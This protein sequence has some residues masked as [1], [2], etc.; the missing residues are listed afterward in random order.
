MADFRIAPFSIYSSSVE[1]GYMA[2]ISAS[3]RPHIDLTNMKTDRYGNFNDAPMQGPFTYKYVGG[4]Q[5]RHVALNEGADTPLTRPELFHISMSA[6]TIKVMG[7][8]AISINRPRAYYFRDEMAKRPL[9]VRNIRQTTGST[10]IGN[11]THDY[12]ILQTSGRSINNRAFVESQGVGFTSS[13]TTMYVSGAKDPNRTLPNFDLTGTNEY[14]FV[15]RF[16]APGGTD[17]SSR[18]VLDTYAEEYAPNNAMPWRNDSVRS[19]LRSDLTRHTPKATDM[20]VLRQYVE[21]FEQNTVSGT[22]GAANLMWYGNYSSSLNWY[23]GAQPYTLTPAGTINDPFGFLRREGTT[24]SSN[25]GPDSAAVGTFYAYAESSTGGPA[26]PQGDGNP[27][28]FYAMSASVSRPSEMSFLYF[29]FGSSLPGVAPG[30]L[31]VSASL[32]GTNWTNL[33]IIANGVETY[34]IVGEQQTAGAD[35]WRKAEVKLGQFANK[36]NVVFKIVARTSTGFE[37]DIAIDQIVLK[38]QCGPTPTLYHTDNRNTRYYKTANGYLGFGAATKVTASP[39]G[40][41]GGIALDRVNERIYYTDDFSGIIYRVGI[42]GS[43]QVEVVNI[44]GDLYDVAVD[45]C[46]GHIYWTDSGSPGSI[47]RANLDGGDQVTLFTGLGNSIEAIAIEARTGKLYW[48]DDTN[49]KI[50]VGNLD[51]TGTPVD[52]VTSG[53]GDIRG[54]DIDEVG[55]YLYYISLLGDYY[56]KR[57][58]LNGENNIQILDLGSDESLGLQVDS[59]LGK[60]YWTTSGFSAPYGLISRANLDGTN[61]EILLYGDTTT[62]LSP[63]GLA[64][65]PTSGKMYWAN[66][67]ATEDGVYVANMP[68]K[69]VY[70]NGY[71]THAIP[72]SSLQYSWIKASATTDRTQL[73]GYQSS[74]SY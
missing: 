56:I 70:D 50:Q 68:E 52:L 36:S 63:R 49:N 3:F 43:G 51:G 20:G 9:N 73:L 41:P 12:D 10:I 32:D 17:V 66:N 71:V 69:P 42:D 24:P 14:V 33:E 29:M 26:G 22:T 39:T 65:D 40:A 48:G 62:P 38:S 45:P 53:V 37:S 64:L 34:N 54:M 6:G 11:Y 58:N 23:N 5:Y 1:T 13:L 21:S 74:G 67:D 44:G 59:G 35:P 55:G 46:G 30:F 25:T 31:N 57:V 28:I 15:E 4:S 2:D 27:N 18:G 8:D 47:G 19:V 7:P 72:Q 16:N 60:V 61:K